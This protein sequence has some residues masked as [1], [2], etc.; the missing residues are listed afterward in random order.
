MTSW[1]EW[2]LVDTSKT[3]VAWLDLT[4]SLRGPKHVV[5][6]QFNEAVHALEHV[7]LHQCIRVGAPGIE[8]YL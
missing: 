4:Q 5:Q 7:L 8:L 3:C 2:R 1:G 6:I